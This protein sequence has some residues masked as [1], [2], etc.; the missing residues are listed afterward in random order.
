MTTFVDVQTELQFLAA[1]ISSEIQGRTA[2]QDITVP[3]PTDPRDELYFLKFVSWSYVALMEAFPIALK[4]LT[5][6]LRSTDSK[7]YAHFT[8]TKDVVSAF[9]AIQSHNLE[10]ESRSGERHNRIAQVWMADNGGSPVTWDVCCSALCAQVFEVFKNLRALW[11]GVISDDNDKLDFLD[12]LNSAFESEWPAHMFDDAIEV[13]A[14]SI[15]LVDF[16]AVAYRNTRLESWRKLTVL[17]LDRNAAKN[18]VERAITAELRAIF[19]GA[20]EG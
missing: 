11:L 13:A 7:A 20:T 16:N 18:A 1:A 8:K 4:Q 9:R 15:G 5:G 6:L 3:I 14:S 10:K 17:F 12:K 19:G 2:I